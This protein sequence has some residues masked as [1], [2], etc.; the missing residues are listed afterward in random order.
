MN[1]LLQ[2]ANPTFPIQDKFGNVQ[3]SFG[4][5]KLEYVA[6]LIFSSQLTNE[7]QIEG[8]GNRFDLLAE[9]S[10]RAAICLLNAVQDKMVQMANEQQQKNNLILNK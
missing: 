1:H 2:P 9:Q 5:T 10:T 3:I 7:D 4:L 8:M 6:A